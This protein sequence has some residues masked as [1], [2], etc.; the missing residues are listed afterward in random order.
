MAG[1]HV[2]WPPIIG[3]SPNYLDWGIKR[4]DRA[5]GPDDAMIP[6]GYPIV[7]LMTYAKQ[8]ELN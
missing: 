5:I 7:I 2:G 6:L 1:E 4:A 3:I 8:A